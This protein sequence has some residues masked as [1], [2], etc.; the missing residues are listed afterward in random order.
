MCVNGSYFSFQV[1]KMKQYNRN[2]NHLNSQSPRKNLIQQHHNQFNNHKRAW[3]F[4]QNNNNYTRRYNGHGGHGG[5]DFYRPNN[6]H[7]YGYRHANNLNQQRYR[8]WTTVASRIRQMNS[9]IGGTWMNEIQ[10][11]NDPN[12]NPRTPHSK[13]AFFWNAESLFLGAPTFSR[14]NRIKS[15]LASSS[16]NCE[17]INYL[18]LNFMGYL[19]DSSKRFYQINVKCVYLFKGLIL[20]SIIIVCFRNH[21]RRIIFFG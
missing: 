20:L 11:P 10:V 21:V 1:K 2:E 7:H 9:R 13:Y 8:R 4:Q 15:F 19:P 3:G 5:G 12:T 16:S 18:Y 17:R 6:N 14:V